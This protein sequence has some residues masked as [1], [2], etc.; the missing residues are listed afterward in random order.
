MRKKRTSAQLVTPTDWP[1]ADQ[2]TTLEKSGVSVTTGHNIDFVQHQINNSKRP[3]GIIS[4]AINGHEQDSTC[5]ALQNLAELLRFELSIKH[6]PGKADSRRMPCLA[7]G[8]SPA[9]ITELDKLQY[10]AIERVQRKKLDKFVKTLRRIEVPTIRKDEFGGMSI[11]LGAP[12]DVDQDPSSPSDMSGTFFSPCDWPLDV[13]EYETWDQRSLW[14]DL[15]RVRI[16]P[17][18]NLQVPETRARWFKQCLWR[19]HDLLPTSW[20]L[21]WYVPKFIS[22]SCEAE[23]HMSCYHCQV[24]LTKRKLATLAPFGMSSGC[25]CPNACFTPATPIALSSI[26]SAT[27]SG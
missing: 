12:L 13:L 25:V 18:I 19:L 23:I 1:V 2:Y 15:A 17:A 14:R 10:A 16:D 21:C 4:A 20:G 24:M 3:P 22:L 8:V 7:P 27:A 26:T 9:N 6:P 5:K 11:A